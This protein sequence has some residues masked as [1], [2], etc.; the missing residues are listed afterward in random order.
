MKKVFSNLYSFSKSDAVKGFIVAVLG[1][2]VGTV[3]PIIQNWIVSD[4]WNIPFDWHTVVKTAVGAASAYMMKQ[5]LTNS[6]GDFLGEKRVINPPMKV[7]EKY[8]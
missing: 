4:N 7:D 3:Y 8:K 6:N 2:V 5:F 1:A